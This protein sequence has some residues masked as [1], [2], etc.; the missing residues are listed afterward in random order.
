MTSVPINQHI[1]LI[2]HRRHLLCQQD[3]KFMYVCIPC[4]YVC[5][6]VAFV[7]A[8]MYVAFIKASGTKI[9]GPDDPAEKLLLRLREAFGLQ[10][11]QLPLCMYSDTCTCIHSY[12]ISGR[13]MRKKKSL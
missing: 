6:Y 13:V 10:V 3:P 11:L 12:C 4:M 1:L 9:G 7:K 8:C 5:M 2:E